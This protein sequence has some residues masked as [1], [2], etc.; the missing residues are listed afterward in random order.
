MGNE[1]RTVIEDFIRKVG[2]G[3]ENAIEL[4]EHLM[5][6]GSKV[7]TIALQNR[8]LRPEPPLPPER[9]ESP[10]RNHVFHDVEGF[11]A[12]LTKYKTENTVV[13]A[14]VPA[15]SI[16]AVLDEKAEKGFE[17][18]T[19]NP[20]LHPLFA[21]WADL[22][23]K[24]ASDSEDPLAVDQFAEFVMTNRRSVVSPD[25]KDLVMTLSHVKASR[26]ITIDRGRG[27][28]CLNGVM[29]ETNIQGQAGSEF[30]ELP[31]SLT[32]NVPIFV[33]TSPRQIEIDMLTVAS[34]SN[35]F[36]RAVS[37]DVEQ[38]K[39]EAFEE[40]LAECRKIDAGIVVGTGCPQTREW[41][42]LR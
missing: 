27:K 1:Q 13:L 3:E 7:R 5:E 17:T 32:L 9:S 39:V 37:A 26:K 15:M 4:L 28:K 36:M 20:V 42:Y 24:S 14:N 19:L 11:A 8:Q 18:L 30:V 33:R 22:L 40:M 31:D 25:A 41:D 10:R 16:V 34:E 6:D 2:K 23:E 29:I 12:Y 21:P 35:V 38:A